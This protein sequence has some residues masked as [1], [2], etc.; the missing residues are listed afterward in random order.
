MNILTISFN[1]QSHRQVALHVIQDEINYLSKFKPF[2]SGLQRTIAGLPN[3]LYVDLNQ[4][5]T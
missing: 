2:G 5:T 1:N 3:E 4:Q